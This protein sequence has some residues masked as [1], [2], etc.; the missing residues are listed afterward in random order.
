MKKITYYYMEGCPYCEKT[1]P[2]W[3]QITKKYPHKF[4]KIEKDQLP[5]DSDIHGF[6]QFHILE[7]G[8][9]RVVEGSRDSLE[10]LEKVLGL[11]V[12]GGRSRSRRFR[13]T[14]R[15]R[16]RSRRNVGL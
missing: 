12:N 4:E 6:P 3:E 13:R 1:N 9:T 16:K 11:K 15:K 10:E 5:A 14:I 7:N 2:F 8:K